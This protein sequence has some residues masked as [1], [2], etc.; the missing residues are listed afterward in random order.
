MKCVLA[1]I[2][3]ADLTNE[4]PNCYLEIGYAMGLDKFNNLILTA[5][6]DHNSDSP[7]FKADKHKIHFDLSGYDILFWD[8]KALEE[9]KTELEKRIRRRLTIIQPKPNTPVTYWDDQWIAK[10][11]EIAL[12]GLSK[13]GR[14]AYMEIKATLRDIKIDVLQNELLRSARESQIDTF[15][16]PIGGVLDRSGFSPRPT[17]DGIVSEIL[18]NETGNRQSYD[19]WSLR[20]SG[21]YY[22]LKSL[23]EDERKENAIFFNTRIVRITETLLHTA[24]LYNSL[25]VAR[26]ATYLI[27]IKHGG[28]QGR[29][30]SVAS[31]GTWLPPHGDRV[32]NEDE[33]YTEIVTN[34]EETESKLVELVERFTQDLFV[35]FNY[36][37]VDNSTQAKIVDKFVKGEVI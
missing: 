34:I 19:Y 27:G 1:N 22:L 16:W 9:F 15:G 35:I 36:F 33:V 24:R 6:E 4:R 25:K 37:Q 11:R 17:T 29:L 14:K 21:D 30:M 5:R 3:V 8:A 31:A 26:D 7:N 28:L 2:I 13:T 12:I 18:I 10:N 20:K 32:S 23:F